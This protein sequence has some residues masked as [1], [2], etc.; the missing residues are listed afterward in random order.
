LNCN[1][2]FSL[3]TKWTIKNC[4]S[5]C[6]YE[7]QLDPT[8]IETKFSELYIPS[9]TLA[10]GI[11]QL[12]LTVTM[13]SSSNLISSASAFVKITP[14]GITANLIELG[15]SM[16]TRGNQQELKLDPGSYSLDLDGYT[17]DAT[18]SLK[19]NLFQFIYFVNRNGNMNIIVE[20]MVYII[21]QIFKVHF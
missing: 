8:I 10:F 2:S 4:S 11:Y 20:Y 16:I 21:F 3:I 9:R 7:I 6:S 15:T 5:I 18:V 19:L 14:S 13:I 17:F 1:N 12:E